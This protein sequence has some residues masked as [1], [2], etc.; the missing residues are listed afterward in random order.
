MP[1][2]M[3][4]GWSAALLL[5]AL[6]TGACGGGPEVEYKDLVDPDPKVRAD[7]A[8]RL[9]HGRAAQAVDSLIAVLD[10]PDELVRVNVVRALGEI[11]DPR[12]VPALVKMVDDALPTVRKATCQALGDL[13]DPAGVPALAKLLQNGDEN[14]RLIATRQM[15]RI[16]GRA[17][18]DVL[19]NV[20]LKDES[21]LVRQHVVR[22][23]AESGNKEVIPQ[24][25]SA[26]VSEADIVR[27]NAARALGQLGDRSS[28][29]AL[30][31]ALDDP[32]F[33]V[34]SLAAHSLGAMAA[35]DPAVL[36]AIR[37]RL[38]VETHQMCLVDLSWNLVRMGD[39]SGLETIRHHLLRGDPE[40]VRAEAAMALGE[41]GDES[42]IPRLEKALDDKKG[43]VRQEAYTSIEK[44]KKA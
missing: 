12:A 19:L 15:G 32:Y 36:E 29:R 6:A 43:L 10:D 27:A 13:K 17:A 42:D 23:L 14:T 8:V 2:A 41:V 18:F 1:K 5:G 38:G 7:A 44:L 21:E 4:W 22:V 28:V 20:A 34:R 39:R 25:E 26:L 33:K 35:G 40:D 31:A 24:L 16:P 11:G 3:G 9:G 30:I 37:K